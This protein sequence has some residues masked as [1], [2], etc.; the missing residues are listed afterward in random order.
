MRIVSLAPSATELLYELGCG[1]DVVGVT[2]FCDY[3][4]DAR[5]KLRVGRWIDVDFDNIRIPLLLKLT[6]MEF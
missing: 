5:T 1:D 4:D 3:P 6:K 2:W